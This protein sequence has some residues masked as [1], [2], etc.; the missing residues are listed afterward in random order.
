[1]L[2]THWYVSLGPFLCISV[3]VPAN[4]EF[5][6]KKLPEIVATMNYCCSAPLRRSQQ[7]TTLTRH[8]KWPIEH[9][10]CVGLWTITI[11]IP[12]DRP[13][14]VRNRCVIEVLVAFLCFHVA[15][16]NFLSVWGFLS[17][18]GVRSLPFSFSDG[19]RT[20]LLCNKV[21]CHGSLISASG[22]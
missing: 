19:L 17:K 11:V 9:R 4:N 10:S 2:N 5:K 18:Q 13:K 15:F 3:V 8:R 20:M 1:M 7:S 16:W 12:T 14:S 21:E 22:E 6:R